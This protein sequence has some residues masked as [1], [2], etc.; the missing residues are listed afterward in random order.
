MVFSRE[1][2]KD[3]FLSI[4]FSLF[5]W[6][7][8]ENNWDKFLFLLSQWRA[9]PMVLSIII[10]VVLVVIVVIIINY[11]CNYRASHFKERLRL[12]NKQAAVMERL[13]ELLRKFWTFQ[14]TFNLFLHILL[15]EFWNTTLFFFLSTVENKVLTCKVVPLESLMRK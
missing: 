4:F 7:V 9:G 11:I 15:H 3:F 5:Y 13:L 14:P 2:M 12:G 8:L 10:S 1:H 6:A